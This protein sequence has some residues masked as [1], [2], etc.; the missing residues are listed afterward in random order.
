MRV[1]KRT[2]RG[3]P[4]WARCRPDGTLEADG[5]G[6]VEVI[7]KKEPG[8]KLYRAAAANLAEVPGEKPEELELGPLEAAPEKRDRKGGTPGKLDGNA[9]SVYTD[10]ACTG[11][12]GP[13]GIGVVVRDLATGV[14]R[15]HGEYLGMGTNNIAEL[16][17]MERAL[18]LVEEDVGPSAREREVVV[19]SDSTYA[20]GLLSQ[21]WKAK[22]NQELVERLRARVKRFARLR[23]VKVPA[24]S[25]VPDNERCDQLGREAIARGALAARTVGGRSR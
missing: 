9:I 7:Y 8:A 17:A 18:E 16:T 12:P 1:V 5:S 14:V 21:G 24:H 25:G 6:R 13:M 19:H 23:F 22:A 11:N 20:I 3:T 10:G 4:V 15:E 2:L